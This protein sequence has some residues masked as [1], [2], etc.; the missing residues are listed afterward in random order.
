MLPKSDP[1]NESITDSRKFVDLSKYTLSHMEKSWCGHCNNR[2]HLLAPRHPD[3][4]KMQ[5]YFLCD[6]CGWIGMP[7]RFEAVAPPESPRER[8]IKKITRHIPADEE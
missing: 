1:P 2:I 8:N 4:A 3:D 5:M 7:G 6:N